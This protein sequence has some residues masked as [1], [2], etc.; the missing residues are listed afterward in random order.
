M[1]FPVWLFTSK[2]T[3]K[4]VEKETSQC[5]DASFFY[6]T[7]ETQ[8]LQNKLN[9]IYNA[10]TVLQNGLGDIKLIFYEDRVTQFCII[11]NL[12]IKQSNINIVELYARQLLHSYYA[13]REKND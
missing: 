13:W 8:I 4:E 7:T 10:Y 9:Q 12:Q 3:K 1:I 6:R 2:P 11:D 5:I